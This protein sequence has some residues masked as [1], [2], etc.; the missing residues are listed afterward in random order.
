MNWNCVKHDFIVL[1][2][3][4][5]DDEDIRPDQKED[6]ESLA[7]EFDDEGDDVVSDDDDLEDEFPGISGHDHSRSTDS[8]GG[9][10]VNIIYR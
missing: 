4:V 5:L 3:N 8:I 2:Q 10:W 1:C 7:A 9:D 6:D